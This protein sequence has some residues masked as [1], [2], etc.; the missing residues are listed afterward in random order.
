MI[1]TS[2]RSRSLPPPLPSRPTVVMPRSLRHVDRAQHVGRV[3]RWSRSP[4][5]GPPRGRRP[6]PGARRPRRSRS[7][8]RCR[9]AGWGPRRPRPAGPRGRRGSA[10]STP[11][12]SASRRTCCR[13]CRTRASWRRAGRPRRR[14]RRSG[15]PRAARRAIRGRPRACRRPLRTRRL[16]GH[17]WSWVGDCRRRGLR[18]QWRSGCR[19]TRRARVVGRRRSVDRRAPGTGSGRLDGAR[20]GRSLLRPRRRRHPDLTF[21]GHK[22]F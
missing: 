11:R 12:R 5:R 8:S 10:P 21:T 18:P 2:T 3:R 20:A 13:R 1:G 19:R 22:A 6:R 17:G 14:R 7:R 16:R 15:A 9:R 4:A